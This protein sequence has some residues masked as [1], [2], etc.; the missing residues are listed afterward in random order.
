MSQVICKR[1]DN[2]RNTQSMMKFD[3]RKNWLMAI[4]IRGLA[5]NPMMS[6][7][8]SLVAS[9]KCWPIHGNPPSLPPTQGKCANISPYMRRP[10]VI[11][12]FAT[13][14]FW[15]SLY[16]RKICLFFYQCMFWFLLPVFWVLFYIITLPY[17]N[18]FEASLS[19]YCDQQ[20][21]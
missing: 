6:P 13:A 10:L 4:W 20:T 3:K 17:K 5:E 7:C 1:C 19:S 18:T 16:M 21:A 8:N 12:D 15:I 11:Y 2:M 14:P 9:D